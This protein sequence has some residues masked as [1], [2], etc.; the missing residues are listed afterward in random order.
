MSSWWTFGTPDDHGSGTSDTD[1]DFFHPAGDGAV[2]RMWRSRQKSTPVAAIF[3]HAG[4]GY[5]STA[6]E[7]LHLEVCN[8]YV[9]P[10]ERNAAQYK[11]TCTGPRVWQ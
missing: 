1:D 4:A 2:D 10:V 11:L 3:I 5:H 7:K 8:E 9:S 6:N